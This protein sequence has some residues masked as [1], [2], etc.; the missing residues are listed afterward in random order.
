MEGS[1]LRCTLWEGK[2]RWAPEACVQ[3]WALGVSSPLR[4]GAG[5]RCWGAAANCDNDHDPARRFSRAINVAGDVP[6]PEEAGDEQRSIQSS[7]LCPLEAA[8]RSDWVL[9]AADLSRGQGEVDPRDPDVSS[10][11]PPRFAQKISENPN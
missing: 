6:N 7:R 11:R 5:L 10:L 3:L 9:V 1:A 8:L 4:A 2:G